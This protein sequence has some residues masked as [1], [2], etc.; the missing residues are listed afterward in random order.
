MPCQVEMHLSGQ[1]G[2]VEWRVEKA[3]VNPSEKS[4]H[5]VWQRNE[6]MWHPGGIC[7]GRRC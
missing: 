1:T 5:E 3:R 7:A 2:W 4:G 6:V